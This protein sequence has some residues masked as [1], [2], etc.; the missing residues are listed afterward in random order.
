MNYSVYTETG[1]GPTFDAIFN[2]NPLIIKLEQDIKN[3]IGFIILHPGQKNELVL[4]FDMLAFKYARGGKKS[5]TNVKRMTRM[6]RMTLT[7]HKTQVKHKTTK[8]RTKYNLTGGVKLNKP[9]IY[10]IVTL[11]LH[12]LFFPFILPGDELLGPRTSDWQYAVLTVAQLLIINNIKIEIIPGNLSIEE[13][14]DQVITLG[15][16]REG[17]PKNIDV[18]NKTTN[19][20]FRDLI[21]NKKIAIASINNSKRSPTYQ[22]C[23]LMPKLTY[24]GVGMLTVGNSLYAITSHWHLNK[25]TGEFNIELYNSTASQASVRL[26]NFPEYKPLY[27]LVKNSIDEQLQ[28]INGLGM[29][30]LEASEGW[31]D[32]FLGQFPPKG[33]VNLLTSSYHFD[34][35]ST[36]VDTNVGLSGPTTN[37]TKLDALRANV[38]A[39][40][41]HGRNVSLTPTIFFVSPYSSIQT[42]TYGSPFGLDRASFKMVE[43]DQ[44]SGIVMEGEEGETTTY[45]DQSLGM[46]HAAMPGITTSF[47]ISAGKIRYIMIGNVMPKISETQAVDP[48]IFTRKISDI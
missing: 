40:T 47:P 31:F 36:L 27:K 3:G 8:K 41:P 1:R 33:I 11:L 38:R 34:Q 37:D 18:L 10:F 9:L 21:R 42:M 44:E 32:L 12:Y 30:P 22:L 5:K 20:Y 13:L 14:Q 6:K 43:G 24:P 39:N 15:A 2:S 23:N 45:L 17:D 48:S 7:K 46:Q 35:H 16:L 25:E 26:A 29:I 19:S 28:K 4:A